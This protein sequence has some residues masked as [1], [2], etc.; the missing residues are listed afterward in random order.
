M[1]ICHLPTFYIRDHID[2]GALEPILRQ[3]R[4]NDEPIYIVCPQ[5]S[6]VLPKVRAFVD[7]LEQRLKGEI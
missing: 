4:C 7:F 6:R 2:R 3:H 5:R 1:G